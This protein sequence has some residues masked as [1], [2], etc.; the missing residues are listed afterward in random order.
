MP[1]H[2]DWKEF[3][4]LLNSHGV[5]YVVVG[6][7]AGGLYGIPLLTSISGVE[8]DEAWSDRVTAGRPRDLADLLE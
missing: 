6:A 3:L 8:L 1:L 2:P 4:Q 7:H 5:E